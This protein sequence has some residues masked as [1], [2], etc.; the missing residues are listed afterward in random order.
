VEE[1]LVR[2]EHVREDKWTETIA[3]GSRQFV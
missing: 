3:I 1:V 2:A